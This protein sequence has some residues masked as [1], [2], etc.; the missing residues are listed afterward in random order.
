MIHKTWETTDP[1]KK[2]ECVHN[3]AAKFV[4]K[5]VLTPGKTYDVQNESEEF[6]FIID[7]SGR[8]GGFYKDYFKEV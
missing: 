7:N 2:V 3:E 8:I 1:I 4:V 6:Y 5:N